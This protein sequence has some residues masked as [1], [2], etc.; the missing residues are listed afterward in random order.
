MQGTNRANKMI[1]L[2]ALFLDNS[3]YKDCVA[4]RQGLSTPHSPLVLAQ[5]HIFED[6]VR[7]VFCTSGLNAETADALSTLGHGVTVQP[8]RESRVWGELQA[9]LLLAHAVESHKSSLRA[10][11]CVFLREFIA[12][13]AS[14]SSPDRQAA[15]VRFITACPYTEKHMCLPAQDTPS[16]HTRPLA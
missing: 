7:R 14:N 4:E 2:N 15:C 11:I 9:L 8:P 6:V 1:K 10:H 16:C 12:Y 13:P 3:M 5:A